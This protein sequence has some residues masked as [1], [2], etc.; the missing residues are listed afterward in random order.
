MGSRPRHRVADCPISL[1]HEDNTKFHNQR[2]NYDMC[3]ICQEQRDQPLYSIQSATQSKFTQAMQVRQDTV[4]QRLQTE[5]EEETWREVNKPKWHS[6]CRNWYLNEKSCQLVAKKR[7]NETNVSEA[8][9]TSQSEDTAKSTRKSTGIFQAKELCV[10]CNKRWQK[11]KEPT[12]KVSTKGTEQAIIEKAQKLGRDDILKRIVGAGHDMV[13]NDIQYHKLCMDRFR[14]ERIP[15]SKTNENKY[16]IAF[17]RLVDEL[18]PSLFKDFSAFLISSLRDKYRDILVE[19][20]I[21]T[22]TRYSLGKMKVKLQKHFGDRISILH[23]TKGSGFVCASTVPL[24]SALAKLKSLEENVVKDQNDIL[25]AVSEIL[26]A[27]CEKCKR[28]TLHNDSTEVSFESALNMVPK[29]LFNFTA[30]LLNEHAPELGNDGRVKVDQSI[31]EKSLIVS[32]Y[33]LQHVFGIPT[34]LT[35]ATA[36]HTFNQTRSK[37]QVILNNRIGIGISYERLHRQLTAQSMNAI[38]EAKDSGVYIPTMISKNSKY[39]HVFAMDNL[40]WRLKTL[41]GGT[42]NCTTAIVIENQ[43]SKKVE[44]VVSVCLSST[45]SKSL[46]N[47]EEPPVPQCSISATDRKTSRSLKH[48]EKLE[49]IATHSNGHAEDVLLVWRLGRLVTTS[50]LLEVPKDANIELPGFSSFC[51]SLHPQRQAST[52]GYLPLIPASPNNPAVVKEE[53]MRLVKTSEA[54]GDKNTIITADQATYE[55][56]TTV[57]DKN[58][59][60]FSKVV[61]LLGGFH[62]AHNYIKSICKI[63]REAG[64]EDLLVAAG[65]CQEGTARKIF[66]E[67]ADYYQTMHAL[68]ILSEAIWRLNWQSFEAWISDKEAD[69]WKGKIEHILRILFDKDISAAQKMHI[70]QNSN[71]EL[72]ILREHLK[73]FEES[74]NNRPTAVF[75]NIFLDMS[76]ILHR[77]IYYQREGDWLGHL[78]ESYNMLPYLTAAGHYKY[79]QQSLPLYLAEM[80][81]L[82]ETAPEVHEALMA[83]VFVGRRVDGQHNSVSPDMLLEQTYNADAK[84]LSGLDG[85]AVKPSSRKKWVHTKHIT[86]QVSTQLKSMLHLNSSHPHHESGNSRVRRDAE[87]VVKVMAAVDNNPFDGNTT[88]LINVATGQCADDKVK[89]D[90]LNVKQLGIE[91]LSQSINGD[92]NK[93]KSVKLNTFFTQNNKPKKQNAKTAVSGNSKEVTALLRMTQ[94][95]A[96]GGDVDIVDF[97]GNHECSVYPPSLFHE[98]GTMRRGTK[99]SLVKAL[100]EETKIQCRDNVPDK[101]QKTAV[102]VDAMNA[103][104][105]WSFQKGEH[106]G[107]IASRFK[108]SL[109]H[110]IPP[111]TEFV[112]VCCD[113]YHGPNLKSVEQ[114][115][116]YAKSKCGKEYVVKKHF[117]APEPEEFFARSANKASLLNFL[118][119]TWCEEPLGQSFYPTHFYLGGG[120]TEETKT[121]L[122]TKDSISEVTALQ[123]THK[124]ADQRIILHALYSFKHDNVERV[125]IHASDTDIVTMC[126]HYKATHLEALSEMWIRTAPNTYLPIHE[127][128][129]ALGTMSCRALPFIHSLSGRDTTS[130]LFFTGKKAWLKCSFREDLSSIEKFGEDVTDVVSEELLNQART[131]LTRVYTTSTD[132]FKVQADLSKL[133]A[134]KFLNNKSTLL[135]LL[136]PTED[137]FRLHVKRAALATMI[138]KTAHIACPQIPSWTDFGWAL[139]GQHVSP[140]PSTNPSW[141]TYLNKTISCR[142]L[143]GCQKNC[144]CARNSVPCYIGCH[145]QAQSSK[146]TRVVVL[147]QANILNSDSDSD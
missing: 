93:T 130:H 66:G 142:C 106:F 147:E 97:I 26:R 19:L 100:K 53:M 83:G 73:Q 45:K 41:E 78:C 91:A 60:Q 43:D 89:D 22:A 37:S 46:P 49:N 108:Y 17:N 58:P 121:L 20:G 110:D 14:N 105:R 123:S 13:A 95:V 76:S 125:I 39:P 112:H 116:R 136:P 134:F 113:R 42:F 57:R 28:D 27:D 3:I 31:M 16:D 51:A 138:D 9:S 62:Q 79:G 81:Q 7:H 21:E 1:N 101:G 32:Q 128:V 96:S 104:R 54:L 67:K 65:V 114:G 77:F 118:S 122:V 82:P 90:L 94:I 25:L 59:N 18:E 33:I 144:S 70:I 107:A 40:D 44:D 135:R 103:I 126:L 15:S 146:C 131:I 8:A 50:H 24:G 29:S 111:G 137:S 92:Q 38:E 84:E 133:R 132:D 86:A 56:A 55:I 140:V 69:K 61:L 129:S 36:Y 109:L 2:T 68:R 80:K 47:A 5:I 124:E 34:P 48:I 30:M 145:C 74:L 23:D 87:M 4:F 141:P 12:T 75:W 88:S 115:H 10:I 71:E 63:I 64:A 120:F 85:I 52:I 72:S 143:K 99:S 98:D 117:T 102:V 35:I 119:E 127:M 139:D 6:K 11:G